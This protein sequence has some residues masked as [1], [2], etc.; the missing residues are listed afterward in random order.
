[1]SYGLFVLTVVGET[2]LLTCA[3]MALIKW[4]SRN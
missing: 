4:S 1:M 3:V 2:V